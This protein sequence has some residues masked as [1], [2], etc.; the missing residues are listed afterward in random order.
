MKKAF[1]V[2]EGVDCCGKT[3]M[4]QALAQ[5]FEALSGE[6]AVRIEREPTDQAI[7]S[8]IRANIHAMPSFA[9]ETMALLFAADRVEHSRRLRRALEIHDVVLCDRYYF[10][11]Y[12]YQAVDLNWLKL[13]NRYAIKPDLAFY[14][15]VNADT[16]ASRLV[17]RRALKTDGMTP[18]PDFE[19]LASARAAYEGMVQRGELTRIDHN[20]LTAAVEIFRRVCNQMEI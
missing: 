8:L 9:E 1:V 12:A 3:T 16:I 11:S 7:G 6:I 18:D 13:I 2:I 4:V 15:D 19:R 14:L 17:E 20:G 10:S 5:M